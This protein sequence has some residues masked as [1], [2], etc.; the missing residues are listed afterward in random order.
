MNDTT[1]NQAVK[2][3]TKN[4]ALYSNLERRSRPAIMGAA[5]LT[6]FALCF[7]VEATAQEN[8]MPDASTVKLPRPRTQDIRDWI[9][10]LPPEG[11][12]EAIAAFYEQIGKP[13]L[14]K[15][16]HQPKYRPPRIKGTG[17]REFVFKK[18][19]ERDL[20]GMALN[21]CNSHAS[22]GLYSSLGFCISL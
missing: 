20:K 10:N 4:R 22:Q 5:V 7:V 13:Y 9:K 6:V 2:N 16:R 17:T 14:D 11:R 19:P 1:T 3:R 18:A 21:R 12:P 15:T 8:K